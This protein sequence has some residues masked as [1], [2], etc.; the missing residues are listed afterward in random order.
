M[1][2]RMALSGINRKRVPWSCEGSMPQCREMT[3]QGGEVGGWEGKWVG[4]W[5][6]TFIEVGGGRMG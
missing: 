2:S 1:Y 5:G 3:E 4:G 6:N